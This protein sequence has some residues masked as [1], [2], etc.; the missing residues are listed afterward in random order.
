MIRDRP[1][2]LRRGLAAGLAALACAGGSP[3][4]AGDPAPAPAPA[5]APDQ[6]QVLT[7]LS[8]VLGE[9]HALRRACLGPSDRQW[10]DRMQRL[11]VVEAPDKAFRQVLVERFNA[12]FLAAG[13]EFPRCSPDSRAAAR[14]AADRGKGLAEKLTAGAGAR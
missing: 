10:Y 11:L 9:S 14:D 4:R 6:R 3:V 12:G 7:D 1:A 8:Y 13:A 5:R 2:R